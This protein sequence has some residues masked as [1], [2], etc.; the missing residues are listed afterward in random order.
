[1]RIAHFIKYFQPKLGY[2]ETYLAKE[3]I[4]DGHDVAI[5][6]SDRYV[7]FKDFD[8]VFGELLGDRVK[9]EGK[10]IEE[11][12]TTFRYKPIFELRGQLKFKADIFNSIENWK[13][14]I[15][16][17]HNVSSFNSFLIAKRFKGKFKIIYDDHIGGLY[18][19]SYFH[20]LYYFIYRNFLNKKIEKSAGSFIG[21]TKPSTRFLHEKLGFSKSKISYV[22][23]G[24]DTAVF[25]YKKS[26][27][28]DIRKKHAIP[29]DSVIGIYSGKI[30]AIKG[31][32]EL[33][34][35]L[36]VLFNK[37]SNL[38]FIF[39][40]D[41]DENI[42]DRL[43]NTL[44]N[45]RYTLVPFMNHENLSIY[46]SAADFAIWPKMGSISQLEV[47]ACRT[48]LVL[49]K[50]R[51]ERLAYTNGLALNETTIEEIVDK[52]IELIDNPSDL[53]R[54]KKN[55]EQA[56]KKFDWKVINKKFLN[57]IN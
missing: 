16:I 40:G 8:K 39:I 4:E 27:C 18:E 1:M 50:I 19:V 3:Q 24:I 55:S 9:G 13:P 42:I 28:E 20:E 14:D 15:L 52:V 35:S 23:L 22:P 49:P 17:V 21:V 43:K 7:K 45:D 10:F 2:Q 47:M 6:T 53:E 57:S 33:I 25:Q 38:H 31:I 51:S 56:G 44:P 46:F 54:Y 48:A 37:R 30:R 29:K 5:F 12:I 34:D 32:N 36:N 11:G 26:S 41:G